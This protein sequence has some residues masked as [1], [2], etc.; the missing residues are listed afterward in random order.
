MSAPLFM[1]RAV[2]ETNERG[3]TEPRRFWLGERRVEVVEVIDR[4][5]GRDHRYFKIKGDDGGVYIIRHDEVQETWELTLF[6]RVTA[7]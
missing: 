1:V 5:P 4:W 6:S 2:C 3:E 7:E